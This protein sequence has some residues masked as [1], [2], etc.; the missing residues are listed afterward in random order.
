MSRSMLMA[1]LLRHGYT[2]AQFAAETG[3]TREE[4]D[5]WGTAIAMP[6]W[7]GPYFRLLEK[8]RFAREG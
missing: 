1:Q 6:H 3:T 5:R 4:V 8:L 7:V 2:M